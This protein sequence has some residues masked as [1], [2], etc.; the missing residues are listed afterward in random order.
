MGLIVKRGVN[1]LNKLRL[2]V[3]KL[4]LDAWIDFYLFLVYIL[5][6][7]ENL[8]FLIGEVCFGLYRR[9]KEGDC[10]ARP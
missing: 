1:L 9:S 4:P 7:L 8:P 3:D 10:T 6:Q 2:L 5:Y